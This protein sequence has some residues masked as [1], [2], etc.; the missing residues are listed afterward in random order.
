MK[1]L[2]VEIINPQDLVTLVNG[3]VLSKHTPLYVPKNL[4]KQLERITK[5][6]GK[7]FYVTARAPI[8]TPV[9]DWTSKPAL[10]NNIRATHII[11]DELREQRAY[12]A[13]AQITAS[14]SWKQVPAPSVVRE[15]AKQELAEALPLIGKLLNNEAIRKSLLDDGKKVDMEALINLAFYAADYVPSQPIIVEVGDSDELV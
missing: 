6:A 10:L 15:K 11:L 5:I 9:K 3:G 13:C 4:I 2:K 12:L 1:T 8:Y 14:E 7:S